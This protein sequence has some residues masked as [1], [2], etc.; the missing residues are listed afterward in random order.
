M[1]PYDAIIIGAGPAGCASAL[2]LHRAGYEVLVLDRASFPRDKVCGEFVSPAADSILD[3]LGVLNSIEEKKPERVR[4]VF[5]SSYE[6]PEL[7]IDYPPIKKGQGSPTSLSVP[8]FLLDNLLINRL[9][10]VGI[11]V[12]EKHSVEDFIFDSGNVSGVTVRDP[13]N[14]K[15]NILAK[16]VVDAGGRNA[17][18]LRRL[19]LKNNIKGE[20][21]IAIAAHWKNVRLPQAYCYM[22]VGDPGYTGM[23]Q[24]GLDVVNAVMI[25][26]ASQI[27]GQNI[28][29]FY[30]NGIY[31]NKK[32]KE[33]LEGAELVEEPRTVE[34]LAFSVKAP[35]CGGLVLVG[36]A[37]GFIDP[38]TGE[39]IYLSLRSAQLA[40]QILDSAFQ[41]KDFSKNKLAGYEQARSNEFS[42]KFTLSRILQKV[43]YNRGL[44]DLVVKNLSKNPSLADEIV[45]VIGDYLP[46]RNAVSLRFLIKFL[47]GFLFPQKKISY[48]KIQKAL[49]I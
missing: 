24:V 29:E 32:R 6:G 4:G 43:I 8:R 19:N 42:A 41:K 16:I 3:D 7:G 44:C 25:T 45:G 47:R 28:T 34:S 9:K 38:F 48:L 40:A 22:H 46:A 30:K 23:A 26:G 20:G 11:K 14:K 2:F 35:E 1:K 33:L 39:G 13:E 15:F 27:K 36:D 17:I 21:K 18:S 31:K 5:I 37:A 49:N 12:L 10:N